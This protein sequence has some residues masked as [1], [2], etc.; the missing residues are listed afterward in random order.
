MCDPTPAPRL[1]VDM[2]GVLA[3][4]DRG[5]ALHFGPHGGKVVLARSDALTAHWTPSKDTPALYRA[6]LDLTRAL[7]QMRRGG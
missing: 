7:T 6:S 5:Y 1:F 2:D 4:F 3:D